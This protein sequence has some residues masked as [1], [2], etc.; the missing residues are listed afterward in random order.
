MNKDFKMA[1]VKDLMRVH[2][3]AIDKEIWFFSVT[4]I[5]KSLEL[6]MII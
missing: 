1:T 5:L 4:Y 2:Y 6:W 3:N